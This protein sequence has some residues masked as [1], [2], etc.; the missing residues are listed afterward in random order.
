MPFYLGPLGRLTALPDP[1]PGADTSPVWSGGIH[2]ALG[3]TTTRDRIA[4]SRRRSWQLRWEYLTQ[5]QESFI[6]AIDQGQVA[7]PLR[8]IDPHTKNRLSPQHASGGT[9]LRATTGFTATAGTLSWALAVSGDSSWKD[10]LDGSIS[11]SVPVTSGGVLKTSTSTN[12]R[13]PLVTGEQITASLW[14][15][16]SAINARIQIIPYD[17]AG[18][19]GSAVSGTST[20]M[21]GSYVRRSVSL[22]PSSTQVSCVIALD[23]PSG[24][25]AGTA[26]V[27]ALQVETA[28]SA[29]AWVPGEGCPVVVSAGMPLSYPMYP[30]Q[31]VGLDLLE[32]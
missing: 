11:W 19:A 18:A 20:A 6:A 24:Q 9:Y 23:V 15:T 29:S 22:T 1:S 4:G 3:G 25:A 27:T 2:R 32:V 16:G 28:A 12:D 7:D 31:S 8:L 21:T 26:T 17:T 5:A 30:Y 10:M 14:V 13:I